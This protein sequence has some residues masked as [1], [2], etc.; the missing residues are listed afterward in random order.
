MP[1]ATSEPRERLLRKAADLFYAEGISR[2]GVDRIIGEA[3]VTRATFYR[4]FPGK[5]DLVLAYLL[6]EDARIRT[7][8]TGA[9]ESGAE[10]GDVLRGI[11]SGIGGQI[12]QP[13]FRGCP[14]INAAAEYPN[15]GEPVHRAVTDHRE[16]FLRT[17]TDLMRKHREAG[18][19]ESGRR[20]LMLRDGAMVSGYLE[21]PQVAAETLMAGIE[22]LLSPR[23]APAA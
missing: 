6:D 5:D 19:E 2:V 15:P 21:N 7:A 4:H 11:G 16:W 14:F 17:V 3:K 23:S 1:T 13:R 12:C 9:I 10:P 22:D 8:V 18:A 20:Y